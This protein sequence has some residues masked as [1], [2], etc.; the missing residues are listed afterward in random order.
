MQ[1]A[2]NA[3]NNSR[4]SFWLI[5]LAIAA[6]IVT[7]FIGSAFSYRSRAI[8]LEQSIVAQYEDNQNAYSRM[9][10]VIA[11]MAQVPAMYRD[12]VLRV[13]DNA[14]R[15][16]YGA[17]GSRALFQAIQEHNPNVDAGLYTRLQ[18]TIESQRTQFAAGQNSLVDKKREYRTFLTE[19]ALNGVYNSVFGFGFPRINLNQYGI[20]TS[21][22][23]Q[24]TFRTGRD[25]PINL[26]PGTTN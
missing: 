17:D 2:N 1:T 26:R 21:A 25:E 7:V 16:R 24:N 20:V 9:R 18:A 11:E 4:R 8:R 15:G 14:M 23:T 5:V 19:S 6:L 10:T 22:E 3:P 12:D 13:Y